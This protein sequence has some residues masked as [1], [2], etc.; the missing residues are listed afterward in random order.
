MWRKGGCL[1]W[2]FGGFLE[3]RSFWMSVTPLLG[4]TSLLKAFH[5]CF[6]VLFLVCGDCF[7]CTLRSNTC[8]KTLGSLGSYCSNLCTRCTCLEHWVS[9]CNTPL[10]KLALEVILSYVYAYVLKSKLLFIG[11]G[12]PPNSLLSDID[13]SFIHLLLYFGIWSPPEKWDCLL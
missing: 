1:L 10:S 8:I 5:F 12:R 11:L 7:V 13:A 3:G 9:A 2:S 6:H 4:Q